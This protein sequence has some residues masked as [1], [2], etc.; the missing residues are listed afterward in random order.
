MNNSVY[1]SIMT[2]LNEVLEDDK[3][4]K[5]T[6]KRQE[7]TVDSAKKREVDDVKGNTLPL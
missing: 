7:E 5:Q 2:G 3:S 6:L 1:E 4:G